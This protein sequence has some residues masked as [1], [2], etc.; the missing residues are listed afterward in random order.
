M[1]LGQENPNAVINYV[2]LL[3]KKKY[4]K[5]VV[6]V[7]EMRTIAETY[8]TLP[9]TSDAKLNHEFEEFLKFYHTADPRT[10][11]K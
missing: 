6:S 11:Q 8:L 1:Q 4:E 7:D 10:Y 2:A 5:P 9:E 3:E